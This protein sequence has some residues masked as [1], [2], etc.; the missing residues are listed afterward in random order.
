MPENA[1]FLANPFT[2]CLSHAL[3]PQDLAGGVGA[4]KPENYFS[5]DKDERVKWCQI[6]PGADL[7]YGFICG[8]NSGCYSA[9]VQKARPAATDASNWFPVFYLPYANNETFRITLKNRQAGVPDP[10]IFITSAVDGCSVFIEGEPTEPTVYH[11]NHSGGA[12]PALVGNQVAWDAYYDPKR[13]GMEQRVNLTHSPKALRQ[14][15]PLPAAT[16]PKAV[17][18]TEYMDLVHERRAGFEQDVYKRQIRDEVKAAN[19]KLKKIRVTGTDYKPCG[20][21]FGWRRN[22]RWTF[23]YQ[24]RA[25]MYYL[26]EAKKKGLSGGE[27]TGN[28]P[29]CR[30]YPLDCWEFFPNGKGRVFARPVVR[31]DPVVDWMQDFN[32]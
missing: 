3:H 17:H 27:Q 22:G 21:V 6:V 18:A 14:N 28:R 25:I 30:E 31:R 32:M 23:Y 2:F 20:T 26:W 11:V 8:S 24:K 7:P 13:A 9:K 15:P 4:R 10:D 19:P 29:V 12:P 16:Q 1:R 5:V